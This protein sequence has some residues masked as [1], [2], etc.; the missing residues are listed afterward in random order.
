MPVAVR[1]GARHAQLSDAIMAYCL[2]LQL[3]EQG[4]GTKLYWVCTDPDGTSWTELYCVK[5]SRLKSSSEAVRKILQ[6]IASKYL[7]PSGRY[8]PYLEALANAGAGLRTALFSAI[9]DSDTLQLQQHIASLPP[10]T[11][12]DIRTDGSVQV[13]WNFVFFGDLHN[14]APPRS[15]IRDFDD[16]WSSRL[17]VN[18]RYILTRPARA[19][20]PRSSLK[21]LLTL[22]RKR[23]AKATKILE[24]YPDLQRQLQELRAFDVGE[25][26]NW[27]EC[28]TLW[29]KIKDCNS[30]VYI[31]AHTAEDKLYLED[32]DEL[33]IETAFKYEINA[34]RFLSI[35]KKD[36]RA[37]TSTLCFINGCRTAA[38]ELGDDFLSVT[39]STGFLGF[40][41]SE[42][43]ISEEWATRYAVQFLHGLIFR[44]RSVQEIYDELRTDC[45]PLSL[46][47]SCCANPKLTVEQE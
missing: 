22:H 34:A 31:F 12:L 33:D 17:T 3:T 41:G 7:V 19:Q 2:Q 38:G 10:G 11:H 37:Q 39:S 29:K 15:D 46:W 32:E 6:A 27:P 35:F 5:K 40:I 24:K 25:C 30:I 23:F 20:I 42:A 47:Y 8:E 4:D 1:V 26:N 13:P 9:D 14:I 21:S 36:A 44:S 43:E 18:V 16:Y 45:F 28:E